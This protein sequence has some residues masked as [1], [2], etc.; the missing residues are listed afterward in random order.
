M[1]DSDEAMGRQE[2][3]DVDLPL[4]RFLFLPGQFKK[5]RV[6][7]NAYTPVLNG[8][9]LETSIFRIDDLEPKDI[10][11]I[12]TL[13]EE[14]GERTVLA[15]AELMASAVTRAGLTAEFDDLPI[16]RHGNILGWPSGGNDDDNHVARSLEQRQELAGASKLVLT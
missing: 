14:M 2:S 1:T 9:R 10:D 4:A 13:V 7:P 5:G 3:P 8:G 11:G 15:R 16:P 6:R 12:A